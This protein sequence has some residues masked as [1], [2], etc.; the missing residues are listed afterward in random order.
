MWQNFHKIS[1]KRAQAETN[2][3]VIKKDGNQTENDLEKANA[4]AETLGEIHNTHK[5]PFFDDNFKKEVDDKIAENYHLFNPLASYVD[6][7][8]SEIKKQL[9]KTK[10][11]SAPGQDCIRYTVLKQCSEIVFAN[12]EQI[13]NICLQTGYFPE[14]W[15]Q[16]MGTMIPKPNKNHKITT[17]YRPISLLSF[18]GK[19]FEKILANRIKGELEKRKFFSQWQLGYRNKRCAMEHILR[20]TDDA[21]TGLQANRLGVAVF[22]VEKAFDSVWH[23]GL[24]YKLMNSELPNK[25]IRL[26]SSFISDRTITVKINDEMSD[27]VKLNAGTPQ[28]SVLSPLLFL[29][30]VNDIPVDPMNNQVKISQF[31]DDLDM[32]TF[33]PN[34]TY[35]Q[36]RIHKTFIGSRKVVLQMEN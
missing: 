15:K 2:N 4:F 3:P 18:I 7:S 14:P 25:I 20:L 21:L 9:S 22:I 6:V 10:G 31:A 12:L 17:N 16:A 5:G 30:Y 23:N 36:Y 19:L 26:M 35:V 28:G 34:A 33:G 29:M 13:Y 11:R 1:G 24:R 27:K 32:W 8:I